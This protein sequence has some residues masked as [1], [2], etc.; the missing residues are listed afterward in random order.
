MEGNKEEY[1]ENVGIGNGSVTSKIVPALGHPQVKK[2]LP[3]LGSS[4]DNK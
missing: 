1:G 4:P 3:R 2:R